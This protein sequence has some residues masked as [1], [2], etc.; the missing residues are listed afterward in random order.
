[1]KSAKETMKAIR[2]EI[3]AIKRAIA[4]IELQLRQM[5]TGSWASAVPPHSEQQ[6]VKRPPG[7]EARAPFRLKVRRSN[8]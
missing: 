6:P 4:A 7:V 3:Q 8:R 1:M 5:E 2:E